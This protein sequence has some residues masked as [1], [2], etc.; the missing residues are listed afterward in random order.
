MEVA[1]PGVQKRHSIP[2]TGFFHVRFADVRHKLTIIR[3][4]YVQT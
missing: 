3:H 2:L 1:S 4:K